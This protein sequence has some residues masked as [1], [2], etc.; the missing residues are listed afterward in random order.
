[1]NLRAISLALLGVLVLPWSAPAMAQSAAPPR[2]TVSL[3]LDV[4]NPGNLSILLAEDRGYFAQQSIRLD[5]RRLTA[6]ST[7]L[8]PLLARGDLQIS[9]IVVSAAFFNQFTSGFDLK[10]IASS[11]S[12]QAG[13]Q[14]M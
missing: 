7:T 4:T 10:L 9:P 3:V 12:A 2:D 14:D 13:W 5:I 11:I 6:S 1:M 8:L